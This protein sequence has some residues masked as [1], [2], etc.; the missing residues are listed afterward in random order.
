MSGLKGRF[1]Y[2]LIDTND[3]DYFTLGKS[4]ILSH[5]VFVLDD[6]VDVR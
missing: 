3:Q 5:C 4:I 2:I 6:S 1:C